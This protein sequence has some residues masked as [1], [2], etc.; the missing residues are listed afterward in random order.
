MTGYYELASA[1][2]NFKLIVIKKVVLG[3]ARKIT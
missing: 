3:K 2:V 1:S